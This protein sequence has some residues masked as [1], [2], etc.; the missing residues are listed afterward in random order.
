MAVAQFR[1]WDEARQNGYLR[2]SEVLRFV[3]GWRQRPNGKRTPVT[4]NDV[5]VSVYMLTHAV[6]GGAVSVDGWA[7]RLG[8]ALA[9]TVSVRLTE[10]QNQIGG[11]GAVADMFRLQDLQ[12]LV[13][14]ARNVARE[15]YGI[16]IEE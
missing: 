13:E 6:E 3:I 7:A 8:D 11:L 12:P 10:V 2:R 9:R 15:K 14:A 4:L 5:G 16:I 1:D